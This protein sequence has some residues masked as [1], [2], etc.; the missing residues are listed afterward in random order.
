MGVNKDQICYHTHV[1]L[2]CIWKINTVN[3][4]NKFEDYQ[5]YCISELQYCA[6]DAPMPTRWI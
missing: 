1:L 5:Y 3:R 4:V 2:M 6:Q